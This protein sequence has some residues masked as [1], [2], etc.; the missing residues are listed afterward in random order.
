MTG[1]ADETPPP[2]P[3]LTQQAPGITEGALDFRELERIFDAS[4]WRRCHSDA[5][6]RV[7]AFC[8]LPGCA[9]ETGRCVREPHHCPRIYAP[10]CGCDGETYVNDCERRRAGVSKA[11][12]G[13]CK[14]RCGGI[15]GEQ[16]SQHGDVCIYPP[17][18][19]QIADRQ[20]HCAP[21]PTGC[22]PDDRPVCACDGHT[23]RNVCELYAGGGS[24]D[25][26]GACVEV[27]EGNGDCADADY[28]RKKE[29]DCQGKGECADRPTLCPLYLHP[30]CGCD[31]QTYGNPCEAAAAGVSVAHDGPCFCGGIAGFPCPDGEFCDPAPGQCQVADSTGQC[32]PQGDACPEYY[33]PVCGCDGVTYS[34]DCFR[35]AAG[36]AKDHDGKCVTECVKSAECADD[37]YCKKDIGCDSVGVCAPRPDACPDVWDP[38]CGCN[39]QTYGNR[40]EAAAAGAEVAREGACFCGGIAGFPCDEDEWCDPEP[41]YCDGADIAGQCVTPQNGCPDVWDP[42]CGCDGETYGNDC[43]RIAHKVA[44]DHD[45]KCDCSIP[46]CDLWCPHGYVIGED[47]CALC[48]CKEPPTCESDADCHDGRYCQTE[49]CG[50]HGVCADTPDACPDVWMPVCGCDGQTYG[51][52][53]EAAAAG[54]NVAREGACFC[55]GLAG[56]QCQDGEWCDPDPGTCGI[57]DVAGQCVEQTEECPLI[58]APVCGCDGNTYL[59]DCA[60]VAEEVAKDHDGVCECQPLPCDVWCP[61]GHVLDDFGCPT[62]EC[63]PEPGHCCDPN[64]QPGANGNPHCFEGASCCANGEWACNGADG[65]PSCGATSTNANGALGEV[66]EACCDPAKQPGAHGN[67]ACFEG[68]TCCGDGEWRCNNNA[69]QPTCEEIGHAC[70]PECLPVLCELYCP[71]GWA[72]NE[73][74]CEICACAPAPRCESNDDCREGAYCKTE[75]CGDAGRCAMKPAT[76]PNASETVVCTCDGETWPSA[77]DAAH[78]GLN[79]AHEGACFCGGFPGYPCD[80]GEWCDPEPGT[81]DGADFPGQCVDVPE[82]CTLQYDPVCGCDGHTYGNDCARQQ[83]QVAKDHDGACEC[84]PLCDLWCPYGNVID[85]NGCELCE[86]NPGPDR[87]CNP[88]EQ[89]GANG[90][91]FCIEG[92]TCCPDGEWRCNNGAGQP[93]CPAVSNSDGT[94]LSDTAPTGKVCEACCDPAKEPGQNGNPFCFEG[95]TCCGDGEW[96]CND[97]TAT[98][99]CDVIGHVC[100]DKPCC[101]A[102]AIPECVAP[103]CCADGDWRCATSSGVSPCE[104]PGDVCPHECPGVACTLYCEHGFATGP[105]GCEICACADAPSDAESGAQPSTP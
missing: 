94:S 67:P 10:V 27:C 32:V 101:D 83:A 80:D 43:E 89:P 74:G 15:L 33:Q 77:C 71:W 64:E 91:P 39:G 19:C 55:G 29:G 99:T 36:V 62:C 85:E 60:R 68:A 103:V 93:T 53:C 8:E 40:C 104:A 41:G 92:A 22:G 6:C 88:E 52:R 56:F 1:C 31:H 48:E 38:V 78:A 61:Y 2:S 58:L 86:C 45:G 96:H 37:E 76:C 28:C 34:N 49:T 20:G 66:C 12:D 26:P 54:V 90:N 72:T 100:E 98:P 82:A 14:E 69:G 87:C 57:L 63:Q 9:A 30:V 5:D 73:E 3:E 97:A 95:A 84:P 16:C 21:P 46:A 65:Q 24:L 102:T 4:H 79:V 25:Y 75:A 13:R 50:G 11:H 23:Y 18:S 51:N 59:N 47:G 44:K 81:C 17:G 35:I 70:E 105:D 42:V 7:G